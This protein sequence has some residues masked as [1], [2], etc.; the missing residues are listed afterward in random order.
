MKPWG[1]HTHTHTHT[2][3]KTWNKLERSRVLSHSFITDANASL[4]F[5]MLVCFTEWYC[6]SWPSRVVRDYL[7]IF[8]ILDSVSLLTIICL[9]YGLGYAILSAFYFVQAILSI[10]FSIHLERETP[11]HRKKSRRN[12]VT[13]AHRKI[14]DHRNTV[15]W[16]FIHRIKKTSTPQIPMSP[17]ANTATGGRDERPKRSLSWVYLFSRQFLWPL[18]EGLY[19][20]ELVERAVL[21]GHS[22]S[23]IESAS[24]SSR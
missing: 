6:S 16:D 19:L 14:W 9:E 13:I 7:I 2:Q 23:A 5:E 8:R 4:L 21:E 24:C 22:A 10:Q 12:T 18:Q 3:K 1:T 11:H 15:N 20:T 17:S